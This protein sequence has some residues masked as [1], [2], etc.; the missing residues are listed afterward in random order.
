MRPCITDNSVGFLF[1]SSPLCVNSQVAFYYIPNYAGYFLPW[2]VRAAVVG[3]PGGFTFFVFLSNRNS[4][5]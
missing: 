5:L 4:C 2:Y 3:S 1:V